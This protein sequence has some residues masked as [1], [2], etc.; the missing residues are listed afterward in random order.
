MSIALDKIKCDDIIETKS[1]K[2]YDISAVISGTSY[3]GNRWQMSISIKQKGKIMKILVCLLLT[4][5]LIASSLF[6][7]CQ[8]ASTSTSMSNS[9][10]TNTPSSVTSISTA[11][12]PT[13]A[14]W[15]DQFGTPQYGGDVTI[16]TDRTT[17]QLDPDALGI[18]VWCYEPLLYPSWTVDRNEWAMAGSF[19]PEKYMSGNLGESWELVDPQTITVHLRQDVHWQNKPPVN[20]REFT[21]DDVI[22]HYDRMLGTGHGYTTAS[23]MLASLLPN[24][25]NVT[26]I[27]KYTVQYHFNKPCGGIAFSTIANIAGINWFEAPEWV[28]LEQDARTDWKQTVGTGPWV[29]SDFIANSSM[30]WGRDPDYWGKDPRYP[31]NQT[32][33]LNSVT[34]V[35]IKETATQVAALRTGK[36]DILSPVDWSH[37]QTLNELNLQSAQ[38]PGGD[39]NGVTWRNDKSPFSDI[40]VRKALDM[41]IDR[42]AIAQGVYHGLA[43]AS[44][45]GLVNSN[46]NGYC[47]AYNDWPQSLKDEYAY[48]PTKANELLAEAGYPNG[49]DTDCISVSGSETLLTIFKDYFK[50]IGINME[51]KTMDMMPGFDYLRAGKNDGMASAVAGF[52]WDPDR[53]LSQYY[54]EGMDAAISGLKFAP[55][56]V[57]EG[58]YAKLQTAAASDEIASI[59]VTADKQVIEQHYG[60]FVSAFDGFTYW[61]SYLKGY[62]MEAIGGGGQQ[63]LWSRLWIDQTKK[64]Q[65]GR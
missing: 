2:L 46:Y 42:Q 64:K 25:K 38:L 56:P 9:T 62:S 55:D 31:Q 21:S 54:S 8:T 7:A 47:Y 18:E 12:S 6:V 34:Q 40:R 30:T 17:P 13:Q 60:A 49:F 39:G 29:F 20:G 33:Y 32:P 15:W 16:I 11:T 14:N 19:V 3:P 1:P 10:N 26:P 45:V 65:M 59:M 44:P 24:L 53:T 50:N 23:P 48:N 36:I 28:A 51:I 43:N 37:A 35:V 4:M 61:Q 5:I 58:L 63:I 52:A 22:F 57:L 27:D 41:A